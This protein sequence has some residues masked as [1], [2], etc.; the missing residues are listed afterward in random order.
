MEEKV[1]YLG[2]SMF[3]HSMFRKETLFV[4]LTVENY[5]AQVKRI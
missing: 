2:T 1:N 4:H 3:N 5:V